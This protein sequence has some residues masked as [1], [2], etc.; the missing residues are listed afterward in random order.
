MSTA[1]STS[2]TSARVAPDVSVVLP[3]LNEEDSV[4][5]CVAEALEA[6][7]AAGLVGEVIVVDNGCTDRSA[8]VAARA[9][10]RVVLESTPGYGAAIRAGIDAAAG[11]V[12]VMADADCTYPL[13]RIAELVRPVLAG[14]V[15]LCVGSRL[16]GAT[17]RSMPFLHRFVGTPTLTLLVR[18]GGGYTHLTDSQSGF[19]A[20]DRNAIGRLG[21]RCTG[22]E[23]A[24][25]MLLRASQSGFSVREIPLGYR[26]RVGESKLSTWRDGL[27][28]LRL[29]MKLSPQQLLWYPGLF[30]LALSGTLWFLAIA[31]GGALSVG[32]V[33]W[34]PIFFASI[35][36]VLGAAAALAGAVMGYH[37]PCSSTSVRHRY[38]WVGHARFPRRV[39]VLGLGSAGVGI[40]LDAILF[41]AW[42]QGASAMSLRLAVAGA[43]QGLIIT[44]V[45]LVMFAVL[46][47]L[48]LDLGNA[49]VL[50]AQNYGGH[51]RAMVRGGSPG[52]PAGSPLDIPAA[53]A[54]PA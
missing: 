18:Q 12:V 23:F 53:A 49:P 22:M 45:I 4:A 33:T 50:P 39:A 15:D 30:A 21:L 47:R 31:A 43:A 1:L 14:E 51:D 16:E 32:S 17:H 13:D 20:F 27:R 40:M 3:C 35:C 29:I 46:Y 5:L 2:P 44:G 48:L 10:A 24:S 6:I 8:V 52:L 19:R 7:G 34:Q 26:E 36:L 41:V 9:G 38:S 37:L 28:H 25:E 54:E 11:R 42:L